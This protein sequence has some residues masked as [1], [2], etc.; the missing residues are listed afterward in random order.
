MF[1]QGR[2]RNPHTVRRYVLEKL[3]MILLYSRKKN[4]KE[5]HILS[6]EELLPMGPLG[7][8]APET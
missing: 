6:Y 4:I 7:H 8:K 3:T 5:R 2:E 1:P